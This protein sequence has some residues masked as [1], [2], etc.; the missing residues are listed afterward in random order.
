MP[1]V[2]NY[3]DT[4]DFK[5]RF[6]V[7]LAYGDGDVVYYFDAA[8]S[9]G[10]M[11]ECRVNG[12]K[13]FV[14]SDN[15]S[16]WSPFRASSAT[17]TLNDSDK[18]DID[19]L[20]A[21]GDLVTHFGVIY[22]A[23][24]PS[25][26]I[27]P[28]STTGNIFWDAQ[29][30]SATTPHADTH[31]TGSDQ[32]PDA[33]NSNKGF[34]TAAQVQALESAIT[35]SNTTYAS[36]TM[37]GNFTAGVAQPIAY[38][39]AEVLAFLGLD[40]LQDTDII[41]PASPALTEL[42]TYE[43]LV[44]YVTQQLI[45]ESG[46]I[47][48]PVADLTAL[49]ALDVTSD[50]DYPDKIICTVESSGI[51]R[52]DRQSSLT[53]DG[54]KVIDPTTGPGRWVLVSSAITSHAALSNLQGGAVGEYNHLTDAQVTALNA[55]PANV[56]AEL[57]SAEVKALYEGNADTNEFSD[58]EQ[59]KLALLDLSSA[60]DLDALAALISGNTSSIGVVSAD[61]ATHAARMDNPHQVS[62]TDLGLDTAWANKRT[63]DGVSTPTVSTDSSQGYTVGSLYAVGS[64][65]YFCVD[66]TAGAAVWKDITGQTAST[67][68]GMSVDM[69]LNRANHTGTQTASTISDF[70]ASV[71]AMLTGLAAADLADVTDAG[72][73]AIITD[74]ERT[75]LLG[76]ESGATADMTAAEIMTAY[77][78]NVD[79]NAFTDA[80]LTKLDS[81][82]VADYMLATTY[83]PDGNA[84]NVYDSANHAYNPALA[85][86]NLAATNVQTAIDAVVAKYDAFAPGGANTSVQINNGDGTF[87]GIF[88]WDAANS[89]L[90]IGNATLS[91]VRGLAGSFG[92]RSGAY[93]ATPVGDKVQVDLAMTGDLAFGAAPL[94][95]DGA[96]FMTVHFD[97]PSGHALTFD[98]TVTLLGDMPDTT[99]AGEYTF[100]MEWRES[101]SAWYAVYN[102]FLA[103]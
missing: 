7:D 87:A 17:L 13:G 35:A 33:T 38:T 72:S 2:S 80:R 28:D 70:S 50:V 74:A 96:F 30:G 36:E 98:S 69:L 49:E 54:L 67:I 88:T 59:A 90:D 101:K 25:E 84:V 15:P 24:Y 46:R 22:V 44:D 58:A 26:G 23:Q 65:V 53:A 40:E 103:A 81:I 85:P 31:L 10:D 5:G 47:A 52:L 41:D 9:S 18:W 77:E 86:T 20:Y 39:V 82:N 64:T 99:T 92:S 94:S 102:G 8:H 93:T 83:D 61:L 43:Y 79:R 66:A 4:R 19:T 1:I 27:S 100:T 78:S 73:G 71:Q 37:L 56:Q 6:N 60:V 95:G 3:L 16:I 62:A 34:M 42:V 63:L 12:A 76:I 11:Y 75:K 51:Y 89:V 14:P 68:A 45:G 97:N 21:A 91:K 48:A 57:T 32:L 29:L 55:L